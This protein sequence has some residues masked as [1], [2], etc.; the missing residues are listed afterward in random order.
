VRELRNLCER[1]VIFGTDPLTADQLP[2]AFFTAAP[3]AQT[4]L[5]LS[6]ST[7]PVVPLKDFKAQCEREY[8]ESVLRRTRYNFTAAAKVL[9][10]QRTY[11]HHKVKS[12]GIRRPGVEA[13]E[14][15][16]EGGRE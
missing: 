10:V 8:I 13:D 5:L 2:S 16:G 12:L 3:A 7:L 11:L 6:P 15:D 4:G 1:L 9:D 14:E